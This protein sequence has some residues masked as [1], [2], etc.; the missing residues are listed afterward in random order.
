M[1]MTQAWR[2]KAHFIPYILDDEQVLLHTETP[3]PHLL[4]GPLYVRL[5]PLLDGALSG[6]QIVTA[7]KGDVPATHVYYALLTLAQ[8]GYLAPVTTRLPWPQQVF[9][10]GLGV[11]AAE[12]AARLANTAVAVLPVG[13]T[14]PDAAGLAAALSELALPIAEREA[15]ALVVAVVEDYLQPELTALAQRLH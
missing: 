6:N 1:D 12:A 4:R 8:K 5:A 3:P 9:W 11:D 2:F 14:A 13:D 7:L 15:A 10:E